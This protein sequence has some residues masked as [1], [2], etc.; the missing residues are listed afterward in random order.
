[1]GTYFQAAC[2]IPKRIYG[3]I[4]FGFNF[5]FEYILKLM[6]EFPQYV[7]NMESILE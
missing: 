2:C 6:I 4:D 7:G 3:Y 5:Q 1:M